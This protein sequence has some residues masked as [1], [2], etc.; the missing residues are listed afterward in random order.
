LQYSRLQQYKDIR[1]QSKAP[2]WSSEKAHTWKH[3]PQPTIPSPRLNRQAES[4]RQPV[5]CSLEDEPGSTPAGKT[6]PHSYPET[7]L[8][9]VA[10]WRRQEVNEMDIS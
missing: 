2:N 7:R 4:R 10:R 5:G 9:D 8:S 3:H 6:L 1:H